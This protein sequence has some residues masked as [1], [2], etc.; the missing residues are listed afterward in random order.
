MEFKE[1]FQEIVLAYF[2]HLGGG[3]EPQEHQNRVCTPSLGDGNNAI[4]GGSVSWKQLLNKGGNETD[5]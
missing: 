5:P 4:L 2:L 3:M 1:L